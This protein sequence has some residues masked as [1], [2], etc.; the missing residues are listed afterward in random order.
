MQENEEKSTDSS[1]IEKLALSPTDFTR[2]YRWAEKHYHAMPTHVGQALVPW[3][4]FSFVAS[5]AF[6]G[7]MAIGIMCT[8][9]LNVLSFGVSSRHMSAIQLISA[10]GGNALLVGDEIRNHRL[11][12]GLLV[13]VS[14]AV[15]WFLIVSILASASAYIRKT[16]LA[17]KEHF[18]I[19]C[20]KAGVLSIKL[21]IAWF[22][23]S[24]AGI[25]VQAI[26]RSF[27][28][29]PLDSKL[30]PWIFVACNI[31]VSIGV[32]LWIQLQAAGGFRGWRAPSRL[33]VATGILAIGM[34]GFLVQIALS[35]NDWFPPSLQ[36][37]VS[38]QCG[39]D[40]CYAYVISKNSRRMILDSP[41]T[42]QVK[43]NYWENGNASKS[44]VTYGQGSVLFSSLQDP[45]PVTLEAG[46]EQ[47]LRVK[48]VSLRCR[49]DL[50]SKVSMA[51]TDMTGNA[52]A[53]I[54][55]HSP[56]DNLENINVS[57]SGFLLPLFRNAEGGCPV[58][59]H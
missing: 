55:D 45:G 41:I 12:G 10:I 15:S 57:V 9:Q 35:I 26:N 56:N 27:G 34:S 42:F 3:W 59:L 11:E 46:E 21:S 49:Q 5:I 51:P 52:T 37:T 23:L 28:A 43:M 25:G 36:L 50:G 33:F 29:S 24:L 54:P 47:V 7:S 18:Q 40:E 53:Y 48:K 30:G 17:F 31:V 39:K 20:Y 22:V 13:I 16:Q 1:W 8:V 6:V 44:A 19:T 2:T 14:A 38:R 4:K 58:G 32:L